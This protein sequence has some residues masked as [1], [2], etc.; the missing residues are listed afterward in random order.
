MTSLL[1]IPP[2]RTAASF[3]VYSEVGTLRL[4]VVQN[5]LQGFLESLAPKERR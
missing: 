2:E 1:T 3:G 5:H 4:A